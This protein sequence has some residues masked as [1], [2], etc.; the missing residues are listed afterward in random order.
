MRKYEGRRKRGRQ[1]NNDINRDMKQVDIRAFKMKI[2][3]S[4]VKIQT[5]TFFFKEAVSVNLPKCV[6][7][8]LSMSQSI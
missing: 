8:V 4:C 2:L 3:F 7:K 5:G 6:W 1:K